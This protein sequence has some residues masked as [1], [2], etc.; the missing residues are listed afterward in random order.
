MKIFH[1]YILASRFRG[2]TYIG[3]TGYLP[4]RLWQHLTDDG[5][6]FCTKYDIKCL[7]HLEEYPTALEAIAREKKLKKW[8]RQWKFE[9]IEENNPD[10]KDLYQD[11]NS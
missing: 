4:Q 5:S 6:K 3:V 7:V 2:P 8:R 9:L 10:W 1:V 11:L